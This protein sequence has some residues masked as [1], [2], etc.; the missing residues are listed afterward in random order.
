MRRR[1]ARH[2]RPL[3]SF[4]KLIVFSITDAESTPIYCAIPIDKV[5][6]VLN[7]GVHLDEVNCSF[8]RLDLSNYAFNQPIAPDRAYTLLL[9]LREGSLWGLQIPALP[10]LM[11]VPQQSIK[12]FSSKDNAH[13]MRSVINQFVTLTESEPA[14]TLFLLD[15]DRFQKHSI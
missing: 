4:V 10:T 14:Q 7:K 8:P 11:K 2:A 1:T 3:E 9:E 12:S 6:R 5:R 15:L 13:P